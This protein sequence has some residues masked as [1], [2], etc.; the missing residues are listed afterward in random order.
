MKQNKNMSTHKQTEL[1]N[2]PEHP[3]GCVKVDGLSGVQIE[4]VYMTRKPNG[5]FLRWVRLVSEE[6]PKSPILPLGGCD[7]VQPEEVSGVDF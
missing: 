1:A 5:A 4:P 3:S 2:K 6:A 7:T